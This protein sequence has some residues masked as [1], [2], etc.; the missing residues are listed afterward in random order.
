MIPERTLFV[1]T[2]WFRSLTP[3]ISIRNCLLCW[4][5]QLATSRLP[6]VSC[7]KLASPLSYGCP[8][9]S[10]GV[11][12]IGARAPSSGGLCITSPMAVAVAV[13]EFLSLR[14]DEL[15]GF[16]FFSFRIF[17]V[18]DKPQDVCIARIKLLH[19]GRQPSQT[20]HRRFITDRAVGFSVP[21]FLPV[22]C[23]RRR[24]RHG[25]IRRYRRR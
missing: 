18:I 10:G 15:P 23:F 16:D 11:G 13:A 20:R 19:L 24:H 22:F 5:W 3:S 4:C 1:N 14:S 2:L 9:V 12:V 8:Y 6:L 17:L 7:I 25:E 21:R